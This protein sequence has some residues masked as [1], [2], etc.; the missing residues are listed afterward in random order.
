MDSGMLMATV[1][2]AT[3]VVASGESEDESSSF[4][5]YRDPFAATQYRYGPSSPPPPLSSSF[6]PP[7]PPLVLLLFSMIIVR[8]RQ[9]QGG[10][11]RFFLVAPLLDRQNPRL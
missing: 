6:S 3:V 8:R 2:M 9:L 5:E 7:S 1:R 10:L 11:F 4:S